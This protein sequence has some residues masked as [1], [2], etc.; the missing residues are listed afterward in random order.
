MGFM[1][2]NFFKKVF[3]VFAFFLFAVMCC[4][5]IARGITNNNLLISP[6]NSVTGFVAHPIYSGF[7]AAESGFTFNNNTRALSVSDTAIYKT[8]YYSINGSQWTSFTLSGNPY[9]T[10]NVWLTGTTTKTLPSFGV[11][12]H[13]IIIY[14]CKYNAASALW[15]CSDNRWQLIVVN[16]TPAYIP[17][18][19][20][21]SDGIRNQGETGVDCGGPCTG[22]CSTGKTYYVS[23]NGSDSSGDGSISKPYYSL[24][25]AWSHVSAGDTIYMRGGNYRYTDTINLE[26]RSGT[27]SNYI[28]IW[29]Y[30][31]E[32]PIINYS[33]VAF[34]R[35]CFGIFLRNANYL[36]F[37]GI[38][39]T[40]IAQ[41][42]DG[43]SH[44]NQYGLMLWENVNNCIFEQMETDHIGGWGVVIGNQLGGIGCS[45]NLFLN[46]DS[47]HNAD[48]GSE[49]NYAYG[50]ADG[51]ETGSDTSTNN[52]FRGCR[53]WGNSDD[54]WDLRQAAGLYTLENCWA[55]HNGYREDQ[56]TPGGDGEGFK[57]GS[58]FFGGDQP[59][60]KRIVKNSLSF[61]NQAGIEAV[62]ED[63]YVGVQIY[64]DVFY[65]NTVGIN[66]QHPGSSQSVLKNNINFRNRDAYYMDD[67][68]LDQS[69][70]NSW[71]TSDVSISNADFLSLDSSCMDDPRKIDGS[72]P[73][74]NFLH[75]NSTSGLIDAGVDVGLLYKGNAP[76]LGA[77]ETR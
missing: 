41:A 27:S 20:T 11:G 31:G 25:T 54:G 77:Y 17:P 66:I 12:E 51:F 10:S 55:F 45:N 2:E 5:I 50:G 56:I 57:L 35:Q 24:E 40:S 8:G 13:Y 52:V 58:S 46:C 75:L 4:L 71:D 65:N 22:G 62:N 32:K 67:W 7:S 63:N 28:N 23:P 37:K 43:S 15:N 61:E 69:N 60:I 3:F 1:G 47:Y 21:C 18:A 6:D 70:H 38:R 49:D 76:D 48:P 74:C 14:S 72:L 36:H 34:T 73:D 30:P 64:N 26:G 39:V 16:N 42:Y 9:G 29:N 33:G 19:A 68:I 44:Y 53:A 59:A